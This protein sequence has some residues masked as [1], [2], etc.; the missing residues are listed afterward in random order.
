MR[1][2]IYA[3]LFLLV[4]GFLLQP[5]AHAADKI[6]I[7]LPADAGHFTFPLAQ[8]RGFLREEG[9]EAEIITI[10]GPVANIALSNGGIDYYTGFGSAMRSMLQGLPARIVACYRPSPHFVLLGR[11][12][13]KSVND[14]RGKIIGVNIGGGPDLVARLMIRHFGLDPDKD[15][16]FVASGGSEGAFARMKQG[17]IDATSA[18][19]PWDYRAKKM[20]FIVL[21]RAEELFTYPISGVVTHTKK[22]KE[23]PDEIKRLVRAG[24]KAN[25]YMR[26]NREGTI[27]ILMSTYRLDQEAGTALYD[28]FVKG[29]N[30]DGS[31]PEDGFRRLIEDTKRITKVD[32]EVGFSEV[33]DL[34]ILREAQRELGIK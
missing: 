2:V 27:P 26:E 30:N 3:S 7:G 32:R 19:V 29:F 16:K 18:P 15:M 22:I 24:I 23:K 14:L 34:S 6:R 1:R 4:S 28:S 12:E 5:S 31:L 21:A 10:T 20:G 13:L 25:R 11:P 17:L 33:A 8:K 9:F